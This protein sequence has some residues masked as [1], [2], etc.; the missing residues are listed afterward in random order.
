M[1]LLR[2]RTPTRPEPDRLGLRFSWQAVTVINT[3]S[4]DFIATGGLARLLPGSFCTTVRTRCGAHRPPGDF[5]DVDPPFLASFKAMRRCGNDAAQ[6]M[7]T[8]R[9][10]STLGAMRQV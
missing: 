10:E 5:L 3:T 6:K 1:W 7:P 2:V 4:I 9:R 8:F